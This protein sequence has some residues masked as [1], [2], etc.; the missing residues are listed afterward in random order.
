VNSLERRLQIGLLLSLALL[1]A[2]LLW[3]GRYIVADVIQAYVVTR[4]QHDAEALLTAVHPNRRGRMVM[5]TASAR[6]TPVYRQPLS[7]HYFQFNVADAAPIRSRSLWDQVLEIPA[8]ARGETRVLTLD[9]PA[10]Q[11]LLVWC[12][13]FLRAGR[14]TTLAVAEDIASLDAQIDTYQLR[15]TA[16]VVVAGL[17]LLLLQRLIVRR[18]LRPLD[19][20][21]AD[22]HRLESGAIRTLDEAVPVEILPLVHEF[23]RLL[24]LLGARLERSRNALG[25]LAHALKTPLNLLLQRLDEDDLN[26]AGVREDLREQAERIRGLTEREL[27]RARVA[28][29]G[30]PGQRFDPG[31]EVPALIEAVQHLYAD[32]ALDIRCTECPQITLNIDREDLLELLGNLM[33]NACKWA[34]QRVELAIAPDADDLEITI[35]DDGPGVSDDAIESLTRRGTR[36]DESVSGHGLG[37]AVASDIAR[38]YHGGLAFGRA[39][40]GGLRV[41]ATLRISN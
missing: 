6:I 11:R 10:D 1:A 34:A 25:N 40:L 41:T 17:V 8:L 4:L 23:N 27:Q 20:V 39:G 5:N 30:S 15:L 14:L 29:S 36:L 35:E 19:A 22:V 37:L 7:G 9:G 13:G 31:S 21:R 33:D 38:Q 18:T 32:K 3:G 2:A 26:A 24:G 28:G 16:G 12:G